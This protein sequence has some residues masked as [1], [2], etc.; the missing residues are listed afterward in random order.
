VSVLLLVFGYPVYAATEEDFWAA[1]QQGAYIT[2][3]NLAKDLGS[4]IPEYYLLAAVC[5]Q[6]NYKYDQFTLYK[7]KFK[8]L[9]NPASLKD[10]L[11]NQ[12]S[13][14]QDNPQVLYLE[15]MITVLFP[16]IRLGDPGVFLG[17]AVTKLKDNPYLYNYLALNELNNSNYSGTVQ[18]YL[19]KAMSLKKD[20]P[21]P[22]NN[23]AVILVQNK[24]TEKAIATLL[25]CFANCPVVPVDTYERLISLTSN[26]TSVTIKPYG[27]PVIITTPS[28]KELYQKRIKAGLYKTPAH[29]LNL[30]ELLIMKG[31]A[32]AARELL[33]GI[34]FG[35]S[36]LYNYLQLQMA[37]LNGDSEQVVTMGNALLNGN[38]LNYQRLCE[39][40]NIFF[41]GK[42]FKLAISFYQAALKLI[43]ADD[44]E[45]LLKIYTNLGTCSY[46][47]QEYQEAINYLNKALEVN[48]E[49]PSSLV[50]L[51]LTY[52]DMGD[53]TK[54][55]EY[56]SKAL[57]AIHDP[58]WKQEIEG[59]LNELKPSETNTDDAG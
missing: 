10:L 26:P 48:P 57:D 43:N 52:R 31:N 46:L 54:A 1:W 23:L 24:E 33:D 4:T 9:G 55:I 40:G 56:L 34:D 28:L 19:Q 29:L 15:G 5:Y 42:D 53:K 41:Y 59:I 18:K 21:E 20:F 50:Y 6:N 35:S 36:S 30:A 12:Q 22:Y 45:Y 49:D 38:D 44:S 32:A 25:D 17:K 27:E 3:G 37:H 2:A 51:G 58:Q 7:N 39:V 8:E 47:N 14:S 13:S 16:E 11:V